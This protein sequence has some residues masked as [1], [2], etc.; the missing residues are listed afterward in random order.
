MTHCSGISSAGAVT[1]HRSL[2]SWPTQP[3]HPTLGGRKRSRAYAEHFGCHRAE[4]ARKH[5]DSLPTRHEDSPSISPP[6]WH[7]RMFSAGT[8]LP[9]SRR[10]LPV[11]RRTL[12]MGRSR[13]RISRCCRRK[14]KAPAILVAEIAQPTQVCGC[15]AQVLLVLLASL[16]P[17]GWRPVWARLGGFRIRVDIAELSPKTDLNPCVA[18]VKCFSAYRCR[19]EC[20]RCCTTSGMRTSPLLGFLTHVR[21]ANS[22]T[23]GHRACRRAGEASPGCAL[24]L[25]WSAR[26]KASSPKLS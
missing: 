25:G 21:L 10:R 17:I 26:W 6:D 1:V 13:A 22:Q 5:I 20:V 4:H 14:A 24:G 2:P 7:R 19:R 8:G 3:I 15:V 9:R 23:S 16:W 12:R 18:A 11:D